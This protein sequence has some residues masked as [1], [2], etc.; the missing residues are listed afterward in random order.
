MHKLSI[1]TPSLRGQRTIWE[2]SSPRSFIY[3][4]IRPKNTSLIYHFPSYKRGYGNPQWIYSLRHVNNPD[5]CWSMQLKIHEENLDSFSGSHAATHSDLQPKLPLT[6][7]A[8]EHSLIDCTTTI[9]SDC[10]PSIGAR[11]ALAG[12]M[13]A[14]FKRSVSHFLLSDVM[15]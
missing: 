10:W 3:E 13:A 9:C 11:L 1:W 5:F 14:Q 4:R 15:N 12:H 7:G 6:T 2:T 8:A